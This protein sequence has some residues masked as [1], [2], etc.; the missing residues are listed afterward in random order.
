MRWKLVFW[1]QDANTKQLQNEIS[2]SVFNPIWKTF[3]IPT[4]TEKATLHL[5]SQ[6]YSGPKRVSNGRTKGIQIGLSGTALGRSLVT[7]LTDKRHQNS[8]M[9]GVRENKN[10]PSWW[11]MQWLLHSPLQLLSLLGSWL[12][13][14]SCQ[15]HVPQ[16]A[17]ASAELLGETCPRSLVTGTLSC[18]TPSW[19]VEGISRGT[20]GKV[21]STQVRSCLVAQEQ[22]SPSTLFPSPN[23]FLRRFG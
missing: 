5:L 3:H 10:K 4:G 11:P 2:Q 7:P 16:A 15:P 22:A 12:L 19:K 1:E 13:I 21:A 6:R 20:Q 14:P 9:L 23:L 17:E 8:Q 18:K